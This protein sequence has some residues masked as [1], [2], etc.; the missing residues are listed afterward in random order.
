MVFRDRSTYCVPSETSTYCFLSETS[1]YG[2]PSETS[3]FGV[4]SETSTYVVPG[5][6]SMYGVPSETSVYV[7][8][9]ET[10]M[11]GVPSE[12]P[13]Y[14]V[15]SE[16]STYGVPSE[17]SICDPNCFYYGDCCFDMFLSLNVECTNITIISYFEQESLSILE[18]FF[19]MRTSCPDGV[20]IDIK[21]QCEGSKNVTEQIQNLP[22]TSKETR[23]TYKNKFC[24][25]CYNDLNIEN[26]S[27]S[28]IC[29]SFTD[30]NFMSS[31]D[32]II[33]NAIIKKCKFGSFSKNAYVRGC[34]KNRN[35]DIISTCNVSGTW[36][37]YDPSIEWACI[38][39]ENF[40]GM[41]RNIFC[42]ICNPPVFQEP[43]I[44]QCNETGLWETPDTKQRK[45]CQDFG[46][47]STTYPFKNVFCY[48]CNV[49]L[50]NTRYERSKDAYIHSTQ[51]VYKEKYFKYQLQIDYILD[52]TFLSG[53]Y[54]D[55]N[56]LDEKV[57]TNVKEDIYLHYYA[58]TGNGHFCTNVSSLVELGISC[59]CDEFCHFDKTIPC[60]IDKA[61]KQSTQCI[62]SSNNNFLIY[63]GCESAGNGF[64]GLYHKCVGKN[65]NLLY[66]LPVTD[67]ITNVDYK[68]I[69]CGLC[70]Y[71]KDSSEMFIPYQ[72]Y[73]WTVF[74]V[75]ETS[76]PLAYHVSLSE[77]LGYR[78]DSRCTVSY[79]HRN[80]G[81]WCS[82]NQP[83]TSC[84]S[85]ANSSLEYACQNYNVPPYE[86][87]YYN[88]MNNSFL[89]NYPNIF[90]AM[91]NNTKTGLSIGSC[92]VTG[93]W[94][95]YNE[96]IEQKCFLL[97]HVD[98]H[99]PFK[100]IFCKICNVKF[101]QYDVGLTNDPGCLPG[102]IENEVTHIRSL[103]SLFLYDDSADL[104][105]PIERCNKHQVYDTYMEQCR[106]ILCFPG[107]VLIN[108]R[109]LP[110][111]P[112]TSNIGYIIAF[113]IDIY[114]T[115]AIETPNFIFQRHDPER[116]R[117]RF[118]LYNLYSYGVPL[119]FVGIYIFFSYICNQRVFNLYKSLT[120]QKQVDT[121]K[122]DQRSSKSKT[123]FLS[124]VSVN[125]YQNDKEVD[126]GQSKRDERV[127]TNM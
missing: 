1:T 69:F 56:I 115:F 67:S 79:E 39:Y 30:F 109:C 53:L 34:D 110:M 2:F 14:C 17:T 68:N 64:E 9:G 60:C 28:S 6:T 83:I 35:T 52:E 32:E 76:L 114:L 18:D 27:F 119:L 23:F 77:L 103:F 124:T 97:P 36:E 31:F 101:R 55:N 26:W 47:T 82:K 112:F 104:D 43:A 11:Y 63:D 74:L 62:S 10:S 86:V 59:S 94:D 88:K 16:T 71:F 15:L 89:Q 105:S 127:S 41:F 72:F 73:P 80:C 25:E 50:D 29:E 92:N 120:E 113:G 46:F 3:M 66:D 75:C 42:Y 100:N 117:K 4:P 54:D 24:A 48:I 102:V 122:T 121:N 84:S 106:D 5:E 21:D 108:D 123:S 118:A 116:D 38:N 13:T 99:K 57:E 111:L 37:T 90:C 87:E 95:K 96:Q 91:C 125:E 40:Y 8:P 70:R 126:L 98:Y 45:A 51:S 107:R 7:V 85:G 61:F 33:Q 65:N 93:D 58:M 22:V 20:D 19:I 78:H 44:S 81:K 49:P 12:T